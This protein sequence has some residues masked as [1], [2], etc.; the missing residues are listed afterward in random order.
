MEQGIGREGGGVK[1]ALLAGQG[2]RD[3]RINEITQ[4][5][6][7]IRTKFAENFLDFVG[8]GHVQ[9]EL[10]TLIAEAHDL[11]SHPRHLLG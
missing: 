3:L 7:L 2:G 1:V 6:L 5:G 4:G 10:G 11:V 8:V 9:R